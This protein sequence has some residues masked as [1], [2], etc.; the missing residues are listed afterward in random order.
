MHPIDPMFL[1]LGRVFGMG[2]G[3]GGGGGLLD[4]L[5]VRNV[6]PTSSCCVPNMFPIAPHFVQSYSFSKSCNKQKPFNN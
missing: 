1:L 3:G 5:V 2:G 4:F 6:F